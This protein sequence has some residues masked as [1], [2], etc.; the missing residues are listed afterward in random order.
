MAFV[1]MTPPVNS[2]FSSTTAPSG[3]VYQAAAGVQIVVLSTDEAQLASEG[4]QLITGVNINIVQPGAMIT[5]NQALNN[6]AGAAAGSISNAPVAGNPTK[7]VPINDNGTIR[8]I[9]AW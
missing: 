6:G 4:W 5:S 1:V 9:P 8:Y 7:W 3:T 2:P